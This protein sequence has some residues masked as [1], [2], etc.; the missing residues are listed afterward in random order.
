MSNFKQRLTKETLLGTFVK[1]LILTLSRYWHWQSCLLWY[2][3]QSTHL[4]IVP[5][6]ICASWRPERM[7]SRAWYEYKTALLQPF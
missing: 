4:S 1:T 7:T 2:W 6:L 5:R 3:M